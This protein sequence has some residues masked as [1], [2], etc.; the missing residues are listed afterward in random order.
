MP[1]N[2][3]GHLVPRRHVLALQ[4]R[5]GPQVR[6]RH[7]DPEGGAEQDRQQREEAPRPGRPGVRFVLRPQ[8]PASLAITG[9]AAERKGQR[10]P[11]PQRAPGHGHERDRQKD[12][13]NQPARIG[14]EKPPRGRG[15][16]C[17]QPCQRDV[18]ENMVNGTESAPVR[19]PALDDGTACERADAEI[20]EDHKGEAEHGDDLGPAQRRPAERRPEHEA[21]HGARRERQPYEV[22]RAPLVLAGYWSAAGPRAS[23]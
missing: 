2:G 1:G 20:D 19:V 12:P 8:C 15:I 7:D 22:P 6:D 14:G 13:A 11:C 10:G 3:G 5:R 18:H 16:R 9:S 21:R 4:P 17:G 23:G